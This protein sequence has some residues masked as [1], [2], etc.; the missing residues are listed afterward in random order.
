MDSSTITIT[1]TSW[2]EAFLAMIRWIGFSAALGVGIALL[3]RRGTGTVLA[4]TAL[5]SFVLLVFACWTAGD[6]QRE[7]IATDVFYV[8]GPYFVF[9]AFPAL[10]MSLITLLLLRR[11]TQR[12]AP[13]HLTN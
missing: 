9:F 2:A 12:D 13:N 10:A 8:I 4:T 11:R 5:A 1:G 6:F 3:L 7:W